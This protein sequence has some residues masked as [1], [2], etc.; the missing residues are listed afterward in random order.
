MLRIQSPVQAS[1]TPNG[2]LLG[3]FSVVF[4]QSPSLPAHQRRVQQTKGR[5]NA[6]SLFGVTRIPTDPQIRNLLDRVAPAALREPFWA[7][8]ERLLAGEPTASAPNSHAG[9]LC[10]LDGTQYLLNH[11]PLTAVYGGQAQ[12]S[13]LLCSHGPESRLGHARYPPGARARARVHHPSRQGGETGLRTQRRASLG[14]TECSA[15]RR[16]ARDDPGR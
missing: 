12:R 5:N 13:D 7:I 9:W 2:R 11:D 4:T 10:S 16:A 8:L 15:L 14:D 3:A 6:F 1:A